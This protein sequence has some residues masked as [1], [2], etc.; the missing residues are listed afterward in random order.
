MFPTLKLN[1]DLF[2]WLKPSNN[3]DWTPEQAVLAQAE[4]RAAK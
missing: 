2:K 4:F 3:R 1:D